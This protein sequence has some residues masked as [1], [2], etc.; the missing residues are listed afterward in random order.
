MND[1]KKFQHYFSQSSNEFNTKKSTKIEEIEKTE[2][3]KKYMATNQENNFL[4][5]EKLNETI[6]ILEIERAKNEELEE[7]L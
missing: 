2:S 5:D 1:N 3:D 4:L 7:K 6:A